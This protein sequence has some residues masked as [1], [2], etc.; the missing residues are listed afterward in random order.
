MK[1]INQILKEHHFFK[2]FSDEDIN[3]ISGCAQNKVF[4]KDDIIAKENSPADEFYLIRAGKVAICLPI[5]HHESKVIQT[6]SEGE[7]LG[8]SWLFPPFKWS[9]EA[10]ATEPTRTIMI[11]GK[12]LREKLDKKPEMGLKLMKRFAQ[13]LIARLNATRLQLLDVYE[14]KQ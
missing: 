14:K 6:I 11:N 9:F 3:F 8:W 1:N 7:F 12:C 2:D 5:T 13:L 4:H 10:I